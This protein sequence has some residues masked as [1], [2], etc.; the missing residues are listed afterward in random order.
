MTDIVIGGDVCPINR[1]APLF[2]QGDLAAIFGDLLPEFQRADLALVNLECPLIERVSPI[3]K[4]GPV[5]SGDRRAAQTLARAGIHLANLA[6]NHILDHGAEGLSSTMAALDEAGVATLGAGANLAEAGRKVIREV[7]GVRIALFAYAEREFS[8]AGSES[9]GANPLSITDFVRSVR[10][11]RDSF[12]FLVVLLHAGVQHFPFPTPKLREL[13]RFMVEE[14]AGAVICQH[15][16]CAGCFEEYQGGKIVYGQ[17]NLIFDRYP[18]RA[19]SFYTGYLV[20][21]SLS[22]DLS[23]DMELVPYRQS[24]D[25][26]GARRMR[27]E[28]ARAFMEKLDAM[29][30]ELSLPAALERRWSELCLKKKHD[31]FSTLKGH[32]RFLR[33][34]NRKAHLSDLFYSRR[35]IANL[36]NLVTCE[37]HKEM[38]ERILTL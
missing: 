5:L 11:Y 26:P 4:V 1:N 18:D 17:G 15:S 9:A 8:V 25:V 27:G 2:A 20:R 13:C 6:N 7:N 28:E 16:H 36:R 21:L 30:R 22:G 31:F 12:D 33:Y 14:G 3:E 38:L 35:Q 37:S 29:N 34:L 23:C 24:D 10:A 19:E 32:G